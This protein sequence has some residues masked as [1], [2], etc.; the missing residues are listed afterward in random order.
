MNLAA[1]TLRP[2][3]TKVADS[4][5]GWI[6]VTVWTTSTGVLVGT[7]QMTAESPTLPVDTPVSLLIGPQTA[8]FAAAQVAGAVI[9]VAAQPVP[10][11]GR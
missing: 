4:G 9:N 8:I 10:I 3:P 7:G 2:A 11:R 6:L 1:Y 5:S